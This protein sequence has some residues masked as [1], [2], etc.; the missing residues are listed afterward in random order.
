MHFH[1]KLILAKKHLS[2][3]KYSDSLSLV[4]DFL[5]S[6]NM[7]SENREEILSNYEAGGLLI[8]I[9]TDLFDLETVKEGLAIVEIEKFHKYITIE[10]S[11][12]LKNS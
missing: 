8:D 12:F 1:E 9:G 4:K 3:G 10:S 2:E 6:T 5:R 11:R 7:L